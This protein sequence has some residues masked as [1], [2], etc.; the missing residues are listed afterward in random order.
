M[1]VMFG[2]VLIRNDW[3]EL[4]LLLLA[5]TLIPLEASQ[6]KLLDATMGCDGYQLVMIDGKLIAN[7]YV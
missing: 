5:G 7:I 4:Y 1:A 6:G 2:K 3:A